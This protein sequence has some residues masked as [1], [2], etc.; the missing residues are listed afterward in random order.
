LQVEIRQIADSALDSLVLN[1]IY[2]KI[3]LEY[4]KMSKDKDAITYFK[5]SE[6][7]SKKIRNDSCYSMALHG[8]GLSY[9]RGLHFDTAI[10]YYMKALKVQQEK[11]QD[12]RTEAVILNGLAGVYISSKD[13]GNTL[14]FS[15]HAL[16]KAREID[17]YELQANILNTISICLEKQGD[18]KESL[19][20]KKQSLE[21]C[22]KNNLRAPV[23]LL[24]NIGNS[25]Q[26][27]KQ[28]DS[29]LHYYN[30]AKEVAIETK[31]D[32]GVARIDYRIGKTYQGLIQLKL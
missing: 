8:I 11:V 24:A 29:A 4:I 6:V 12:A 19:S 26:F 9:S 32:Y 31:S 27:L 17:D 18:Y 3:G 23:P 7:L 28:P 20:Y 22:K 13:L 2:Y 21:L 30:I 10:D 16:S 1:S 5:K 15:Q 14:K 25:F